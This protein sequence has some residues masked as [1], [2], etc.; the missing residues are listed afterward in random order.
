MAQHIGPQ[1]DRTPDRPGAATSAALFGELLRERRESARLSQGRLGAQIPCDRS[2]VA[3]IEAGTR[4]PQLEYV[5]RCDEVMVTGGQLAHLWKKVNWYTPADH[6]DWFRRRAAME[7]EATALCIYQSQ[8]VPGLL[9][10]EAY[11]RALFTTRDPHD[12]EI[13]RRISARLSRQ[14]RLT[15]QGAPVVIAVLAESALLNVVGSFEIMREQC[16]HLLEMGRHPNI[17]IQIAPANR[18]LDR[19]DTSLTLITLPDGHRWVYSESLDQGHF[20]DD[21]AVYG[22][23][24]RAYDVLRADILSAGES[25]ALL[26]E[27]MEGYSVNGSEHQR[28]DLDQ[29]QSQRRQQRRLHRVRPRIRRPR[30]R[31]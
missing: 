22:R 13:E 3:R 14:Q 31:T 23:H 24:A 9:Q 26:S 10:T 30:P 4:L 28:D 25:A 2:L 11:T 12:P 7:A 20:Q 6:P 16:A 29:K 15:G 21:P 1:P 17:R 27:F 5:E 8:V 18:P 19:P